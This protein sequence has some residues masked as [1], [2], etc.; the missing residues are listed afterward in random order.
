MAPIGINDDLPDASLFMVETKPRWAEPLIQLLT[1]GPFSC[2]QSKSLS[3]MDI[4]RFKS[5]IFI[6]SCIYKLG[7]DGILRLCVSLNEYEAV[8][9]NAHISMGKQHVHGQK[10]AKRV[11]MEGMWWPTF[12]SDAEAYVM[13]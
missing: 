6:S 13:H 7:Q 3:H 2:D 4:E 9:T 12:W 5:Y 8:L 10:L 1:M 11:L